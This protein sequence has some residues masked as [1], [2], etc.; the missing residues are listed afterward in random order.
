MARIEECFRRYDGRA[1]FEAVILSVLPLDEGRRGEWRLWIAYY[2]RAAQE[3]ALSEVQREHYD[4]WR[5]NLRSAY[6]RVM[7]V[8][9]SCSKAEID[10]GTDATMAFIQGLGVL[11]IFGPAELSPARQRQLVK[12]HIKRWCN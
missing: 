3:V 12:E 2:A 4:G 9:F 1:L 7:S 10:R 8:E 6:Q 11:G 5:A